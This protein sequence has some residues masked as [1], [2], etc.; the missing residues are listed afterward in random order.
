MQTKFDEVAQ[1]QAV[2]DTLKDKL[3]SKVAWSVL[4]P[5]LLSGSSN[6]TLYNVMDSLCVYG[7]I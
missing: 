2:A 6:R 7:A 3:A 5:G 4:R 1:E